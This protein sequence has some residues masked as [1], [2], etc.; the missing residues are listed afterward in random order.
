MK[1]LFVSNLYGALARGGAESVVAAEA[2][3]LR[4]AGHTVVVVSGVPRAEIA[5]GAPVDTTENGVRHLTYAPPNLCFY[6]DLARHG[7][8]FRLWWHAF[9]IGNVSSAARL[10]TIV[11]AEKPDIVHTHNLMGLG[12]MIP[13]MLRR[14]G[15]RHVHTVHDVQL[16]EPSGLLPADR[17]FRPALHQALSIRLMRAMMG[18]PEAVLFPSEFHK[19]LH[20]RFGFFPQSRR[21]VLRNPSAMVTGAAHSSESIKNGKTFLF[22]GQLE[23]HKGI[24]DLL[25]AWEQ[26]YKEGMTLEIAGNGSLAVPVADRAAKLRGVTMRGRLSGADL[27]AAYTR[28]SWL[29]LP[30]RVIEN[31]PA[32]ITEA[33][34]HGVPVIASAS[35]G[36][37]EMVR[38]G[39]NGFLFPAGNVALLAE[40]LTSA[41][42]MAVPPHP[43]VAGVSAASHTEALLSAYQPQ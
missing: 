19:R 35:G 16:L 1:I 12:F 36:I 43:K 2:A 39:E 40:L 23:A 20:E 33:F 17:E 13:H 25:G 3:A 41:A 32:S 11:R 9:D 10:E 30:S 24:L 14:L 42:H 34:S 7:F 38:H 6:T 18:S 37:P 4:S 27:T 28:A 21:A 29:V 31:A 8:L 15:V 22:A 26:A 5:N